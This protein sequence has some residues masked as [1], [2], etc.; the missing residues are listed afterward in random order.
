MALPP[1]A[2][3]PE[4]A[5]V[6]MSP[7]LA[8]NALVNP[9]VIPILAADDPN[10]DSRIA[11]LAV[12][13]VEPR[14]LD[15]SFLTW[16]IVSGPAEFVGEAKGPQVKVRGTG[17]GP[18]A[19]AQF[20]VRWDGPKGPVL[21]AYRAWVGKVG[22]VPYRINVLDGSVPTAKASIILSPAQ[23]DAQLQVAKVIWWQAGLLLE[24]DSDPNK[25]DG[26]NA[27]ASPG[28]YMVWATKDNHTVNVNINLVPAATRYNFRPGVINIVYVRSTLVGGEPTQ[29]GR[30]VA[31]DIQ[32]V[33]GT[34]QNLSGTPSASWVNPSGV[35]LDPPAAAV[36]MLAMPPTN[37]RR[38]KGPGDDA[39]VRSRYLQDSSFTAAMMGQL[40]AC[41][42]PSDW[43]TPD[44]PAQSG[45]NLAHELG[46][47]LGL[48]HRGS[49]DTDHPPRSDDGVNSP[50]NSGATRGHPWL[51]NVMTYGYGR[52][53]NPALALDVDIIQ[54]PVVRGHPAI[55]YK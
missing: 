25:Y 2:A 10:L 54:A 9:S 30:A 8:L 1:G 41:M 51:E 4:A 16:H 53:A 38:N 50:D 6:A 18:D 36:T 14:D 15:T 33:A 52:S 35:P 31:S 40:Y 48:R 21:A 17:S 7:P 26:A 29:S 23:M 5:P 13:Y 34:S 24:P 11:R 12:T 22:T 20:E 42:L 39:F 47:V 44:N 49:G 45:V 46:H 3:T 19:M 37:R 27:T 32:G 43:A 55:I 28:V